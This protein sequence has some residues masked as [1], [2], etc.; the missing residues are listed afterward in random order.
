MEQLQESDCRSA[1]G[2]GRT[3]TDE[4]ITTGIIPQDGSEAFIGAVEP[5]RE[6]VSQ[7]ALQASA[8]CTYRQ[9]HRSSSGKA[10]DIK[11][12]DIIVIFLESA[13]GYSVHW[14][15]IYRKTTDGYE[16]DD[17]TAQFG[18]PVVFTPIL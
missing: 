13:A 1:F 12:V 11:A 2:I 3:W 17:L 14:I 6:S 5:L 7:K 4:F 10:V 8:V 18:E 15:R 16:F 9:A